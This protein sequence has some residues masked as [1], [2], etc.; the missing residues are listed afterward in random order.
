MSVEYGK[1]RQQFGKP[2]GSFQAVKHRCADM[3]VRAEVARSATTTRRSRCATRA[4]DADFQ[5]PSRRS[6]AANGA[7]QNAADNVQNHGGM[8]FTWECDAHLF[9][10]RARRARAC[11]RE[12]H[13]PPGRHRVALARGLVP[14]PEHATTLR[15]RFPALRHRNFRLYVIGQGISLGG[16]WMQAVGQGWLVVTGCRGTELDSGTVAFAGYLP[17]LCFA[18]F[19]GVVADRVPRRRLLVVTQSLAMLLALG[20]TVLVGAPTWH[21]AARRRRWRLRRAW[22]ARSTCR[23]GSRSWSRWSG[24]R[25]C[26]ARSRS[27]RRSSTAARVVG[28]AIAGMVVAAVG[29]APCFFLNG[30]SYL[31][32]ADR[33]SAHAIRCGAAAPH[34]GAPAGLRSGFATSGAGRCCGRCC[35]RSASCRRSASSRTC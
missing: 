4:D 16:F 12:P 1:V 8:G 26:R 31:G 5:V 17:M 34:A 2:I 29:E 7:I 30:V 6:L 33:R 15:G 13:G 10:K 25:T 27:T 19:A 18:P 9:V 35:S 14:E 11:V 32:R 28:P 24:A 21:R 20:C 3:A 23:R 22:S